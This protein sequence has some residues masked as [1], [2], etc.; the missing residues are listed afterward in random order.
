MGGRGQIQYFLLKNFFK[1]TNKY[2]LDSYYVLNM[3]SYGKS[4]V[5]QWNTF[6]IA[7]H[8]V[9]LKIDAHPK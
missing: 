5:L 1:A 7:S 4:K 6:P 9:E 8:P 2:L 3:G